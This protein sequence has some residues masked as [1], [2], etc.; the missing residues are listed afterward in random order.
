MYR[1][2]IVAPLSAPPL[3]TEE[4]EAAL[5]RAH[6]DLDTERARAR[7][8]EAE[9]G[10]TRA[11]AQE[12]REALHEARRTQREQRERLEGLEQVGARARCPWASASVVGPTTSL[13][14]LPHLHTH[15]PI[16]AAWRS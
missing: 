10:A 16:V 6:A 13:T 7:Q 2:H 11:A 9:H 8:E 12:L 4:L 5:Q 3:H 1:C 15:P 14:P